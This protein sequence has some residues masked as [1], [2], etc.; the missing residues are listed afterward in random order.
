MKKQVLKN[1]LL[2]LLTSLIWGSAFVAQRVGMD[3]IGPFTFNAVRFILGPLSLL[4]LILYRWSSLPAE[5]KKLRPYLTNG[6]VAGT[7]VFTAST[8]QQI[9]IVYTTAG[10]AGFIT[11]FY[12]VLVPILG[13]FLG[14]KIGLT[15]WLAALLAL[16]GLYFLSV[17][18]DF[19]MGKGD[20]IVLGSALFW[21]LHII[22]VG[23]ASTKLDSLIFSFAQF[24]LCALLSWA[25]AF[26]FEEPSWQG[27][28]QAGIPILYGGI[29]SVGV[30]YTLQVVAQK[31]A[32]PSHAVIILSM[33]GAFA[34]LAGALILSEVLSGR[35][36]LGCFLMLAG[37]LLSQLKRREV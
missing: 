32:P 23:Q 19:T 4:P 11:G 34:A 29:F 28:S 21:A 7:V 18:R 36:I 13:Y 15:R 24:F 8:L 12:V 3:Y 26:I 30:A 31:N 22:V 17:T 5:H 37:M 9:G 16:G 2:L 10:N 35:Q 20:V 25:G 33:E 27:I 6:L 14:Q 1:D